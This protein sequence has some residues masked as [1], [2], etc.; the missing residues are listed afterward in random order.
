MRPV[1]PVARNCGPLLPTRRRKQAHR[2]LPASSF[3]TIGMQNGSGAGACS[4]VINS[5]TSLSSD[6]DWSWTDGHRFVIA[7]YN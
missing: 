4:L 2:T 1:C 6:I 7:G 5:D 3:E